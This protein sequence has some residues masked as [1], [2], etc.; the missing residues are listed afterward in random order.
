MRV[1]LQ[2]IL[3]YSEWLLKI[4]VFGCA[5][6]YCIPNSYLGCYVRFWKTC[7][8]N[9]ICCETPCQC[10]CR[11]FGTLWKSEKEFY[12]NFYKDHVNNWKLC[13]VYD[14]ILFMLYCWKL[15][16]WGHMSQFRVRLGQYTEE[17]SS[18]PHTPVSG[19]SRIFD[20]TSLPMVL[21]T[22]TCKMVW[23]QRIFS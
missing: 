11:A 13:F 2:Y 3:Y 5:Y 1:H 6:F 8:N 19:E 20:V 14:K 22:K 23:P 15:M 16:F 9:A 17:V 21:I 18:K 4:Y 12:P 10:I 7:A